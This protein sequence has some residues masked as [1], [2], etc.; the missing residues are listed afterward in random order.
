MEKFPSNWSK[1]E[2][3]SIYL[4]KPF[5]EIANSEFARKFAQRFLINFNRG[6]SNMSFQVEKPGKV[7]WEKYL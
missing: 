3:G 6:G 4:E 5:Q 7:W 1:Y 2:I